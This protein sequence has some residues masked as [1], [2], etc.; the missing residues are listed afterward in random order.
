MVIW[1]KDLAP[2]EIDT[3]LGLVDIVP[4]VLDL[5][6]VRSPAPL[7]GHSLAGIV[8]GGEAT[9]EQVHYS[10][11]HYPR[12]QV[13]ATNGEYHWTHDKKSVRIGNRYKIIFHVDSDLVEVFDLRSDP[14]EKRNLVRGMP[15][16][17][18]QAGT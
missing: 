13:E 8:C 6:D 9:V 4:T 3:Q 17:R 11:T 1:H 15:D 5:L 2:R 14:M 16:Q 7:D 18:R 12:E 10:E